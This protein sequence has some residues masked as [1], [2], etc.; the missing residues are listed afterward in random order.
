MNLHRTLRGAALAVAMLF[1]TLPAEA[2]SLQ[3]APTGLTLPPTQQSE[4]LTL[5][6]SGSEPLRAQVRVFQWTQQDG[7][8]VLQPTRDIVATPAML[9]IAPGASQ[10]VRVVRLTP[11]PAEEGA[12]RVVVSELPV[13]RKTDGKAGLSFALQYSLPVFL[14]AGDAPEQGGPVLRARRVADALELS[15]SGPVHARVSALEHVDTQGQRTM[16]VPGLLGYVLPGR[17]MRWTLPPHPQDHGTYEAVINNDQDAS[18]LPS[19]SA[20]P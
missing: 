7:K 16:L 19:A 20:T 14:T 3:V 5:S 8:D 15:N 11:P 9:S 6:N 10:L 18:A 13:P 1:A 17:T 4:A 12:Y 2:A